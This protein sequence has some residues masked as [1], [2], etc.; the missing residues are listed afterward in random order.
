MS[1]VDLP[2]RLERYGGNVEIVR[3]AI[4]EQDT[5]RKAA[6]PHFSAHDKAG[7]PRYGWFVNNYGF[8]CYELDAL[9]PVILRERVE[10]EILARLDMDAW[11]HAVKIEA[12]EY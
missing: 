6:V 4:A 3:V 9:S 12:A 5:T 1:D 10:H 11:R 2:E 8:R 7:D